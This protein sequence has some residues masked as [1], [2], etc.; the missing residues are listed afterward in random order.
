MAL[1]SVPNEFR[2]LENSL[3]KYARPSYYGQGVT[4][5]KTQFPVLSIR[6]RLH[7]IPSGLLKTI[8]LPASE[9]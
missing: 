1:K 4:G 3:T 8:P 5:S 2:R 6:N 9:T 7:V